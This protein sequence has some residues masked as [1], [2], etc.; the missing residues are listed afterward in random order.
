[1][2]DI[3]K[4]DGTKCSLAAK[5]LRYTKPSEEYY[6]VYVRPEKTGKD[7]EYFIPNKGAKK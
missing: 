5:C 2:R 3:A 6:Q 7:C 4:C 1:M